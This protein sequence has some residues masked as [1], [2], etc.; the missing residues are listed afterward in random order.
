MKNTVILNPYEV[1]YVTT[2]ATGLIVLLLIAIYYALRSRRIRSTSVYLSGEPESV[3]SSITP[4]IASLYWGFMKKFAKSLYKLLV[5]RVHTGSLHDWFKFL[6]SW[7]SL[8][9]IIAIIIF[10][11][12]LLTG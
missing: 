7:F 4:S 11:I 3:V 12:A 1:V 2:L 8:L 6:S 10:M 5:E 9:L